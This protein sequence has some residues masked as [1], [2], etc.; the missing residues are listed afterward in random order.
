M[1]NALPAALLRPS[2]AALRSSPPISYQWNT[3]TQAFARQFCIPHQSRCLQSASS[4]SALYALHSQRTLLSFRQ[5]RSFSSTLHSTASVS[6]TPLN[7]P[8]PPPT[9]PK[10]RVVKIG[11]LPSGDV[12]TATLNTIFG[13]NVSRLDGNHALRILHHRR[14]SGSL[15]DYG[16]D[17]I[18]TQ[19]GVFSRN[20]ALKGLEWLR[21]EFPV[22]E[23][24]AAQEWA[25]KEANRIA[26][27]LWLAHPDNADSKYNDPAR[28][29]RDQQKEIEE[30][31]KKSE[32]EEGSRI[33][34]LH[35][36]PSQ[37][38]RNIERKRQERLE[39]ITKKAEEKEKKEREDMVKLE[40][41]EWVRTPGGTGLMKPGQTT[42]VD[43][44]GK[45]MVDTG[46]EYRERQEKKS[47]SGFASEEEMRNATT[48]SQRLIPM[49][50]LVLFTVAACYVFATTYI[51]PNSSHRLWP[52]LSP[53]TA[54]LA[55]IVAINSLLVIAWRLPFLWP[56]LTKHFM[57]VPGTPRA[58]QAVTNVFTHVQIDHFLMN[59]L[60]MVI[61]GSA[62]HDLV[63]RGIFLGTYIS[64]G[65]VGSLLSLYWAN[66][67]R[68]SLSAHS[69]GAS[70]A[71]W[72][73][74]SLLAL[75]TE[76]NTIKVP[77]VKDM[78]TPFY[79]KLLWA[80]FVL[81]EI[82]GFVRGRNVK[83]DYMS[84]FGGILTGAAVAGWM[85]YR[86]WDGNDAL[87]GVQERAGSG[88]K[89]VDIGAM[90]KEEVKEIKQAVTK[91]GK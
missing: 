13:P 78:E 80:A 3:V 46:R 37:F 61:V 41:G 38:E 74:A 23:A 4:A 59:M 31:N 83:V 60:W 1:S 87:D 44:F 55:G 69:V 89:V 50:A 28:V 70:A 57:H 25:E 47:Q 91:G 19:S 56:L 67:G 77:I 14:V 27:E 11:P 7:P 72:G 30:L 48:L 16:V 6:N 24:R 76:K 85:R 10:K 29:F 42:Y 49:T 20:L 52:D 51:P 73:I 26:Y 34:I 90:V 21:E 33:G 15:A 64:A 63:G 35:H 12:S 71:V 45:E 81:S 65:A 82:A 22:D 40:S 5:S 18:K 36:G 17:N 32:E 66:L 9:A 54:T 58:H 53:T 68:G 2:C 39:A 43:L 86:G 84:H 79:P 88:D 75:L 8:T 62:C